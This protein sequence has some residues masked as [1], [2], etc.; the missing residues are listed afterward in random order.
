MKIS[1]NLL[2]ELC[3]E[4][5]VVR[6]T[7]GGWVV[8]GVFPTFLARPGH[9]HVRLFTHPE[10]GFFTPHF[11]PLRKSAREFRRRL[12]RVRPEQL[13]AFNDRFGREM[14]RHYAHSLAPAD[15]AAIEAQGWTAHW[16][17]WRALLRWLRPSCKPGS[18]LCLDDRFAVRLACHVLRHG[19]LPTALAS[20]DGWRALVALRSGPNDSIEA[21]SLFHFPEGV[22]FI[23]S[24]ERLVQMHPPGWYWLANDWANTDAIRALW[25]VEALERVGERLKHCLRRFPRSTDPERREELPPFISHI[26]GFYSSDLLKA[27][28]GLTIQAA[29]L[30]G[31]ACATRPR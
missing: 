5:N 2:D 4:T 29:E 8:R 6:E 25:P 9:P 10:R 15:L 28:M 11:T 17:D 7:S 27:A 12:A 31:I 30:S 3:V 22:W 26:L 1:L 21:R 24:D 19:V 16:A 14:V 23:G 20:L 18:T 13:S